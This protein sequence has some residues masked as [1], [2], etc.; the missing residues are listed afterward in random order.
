[1]RTLRRHT[2]EKFLEDAQT[3]AGQDRVDPFAYQ[4]E[5]VGLGFDQSAL[6]NQVSADAGEFDPNRAGSEVRGAADWYDAA[7]QG[8]IAGLD[9]MRTGLLNR[10]GLLKAP[11]FIDI[12]PVLAA[13]RAAAMGA[14]HGARGDTALLSREADFAQAAAERGAME[15]ARVAQLEEAAARR[16]LA[17]DIGTAAA[18]AAA[19]AAAGWGKAYGAAGQHDLAGSATQADMLKTG[20]DNIV[21]DASLVAG[22]AD[23][24]ADLRGKGLDVRADIGESVYGGFR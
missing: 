14:A 2:A 20:L 9:A 16:G 23:M 4:V 7:M 8:R 10:T 11:S 6:N 24:A 21:E 19:S 22:T 13:Q 3:I 17:S 5:A 18:N 15:Q 12:N 1:M